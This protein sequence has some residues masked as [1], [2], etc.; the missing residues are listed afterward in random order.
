MFSV[1]FRRVRRRNDFCLSCQSRFSYILDIWGKE[2]IGLANVLDDLSMTKVAAVA[3]VSKN[4]LVCT[5]KLEPLI[6][7][8]QNMEALLS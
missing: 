4:L 7:S 6:K 8:L 5:I 1:R 3:L 2:Y